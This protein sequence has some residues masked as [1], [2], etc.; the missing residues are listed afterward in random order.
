MALIRARP[1]KTT[2]LSFIVAV[3][4]V[5]THVRSSTASVIDLPQH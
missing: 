2:Y 3:G 5:D 1:S 4:L